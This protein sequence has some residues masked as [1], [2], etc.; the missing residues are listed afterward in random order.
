M[1]DIAIEQRNQK[2]TLK[3]ETISDGSSGQNTLVSAVTSKR[4]KVYAMVLISEGTVG[5]EFRDGASTAIT[6]RMN[7]Q[8]REGFSIAVAPPAFILQ[9]T[10]GNAFTM[11]LDAAVQV[12]GW[13]S[14][15]DDDSA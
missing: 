4:I 15:W 11:N 12:D 10:A 6:G 5:V 1:P 13:F 2:R 7:F 9:T 3:I 8:A 14:Y